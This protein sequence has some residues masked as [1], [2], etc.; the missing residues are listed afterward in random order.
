MDWQAF[1]WHKHQVEG[2]PNYSINKYG[3]LTF[4]LK[5]NYDVNLFEASFALFS[6]ELRRYFQE[7]NSTYGGERRAK[8][9]LWN[10]KDT[11]IDQ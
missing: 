1:S 3:G 6:P 4:L 10:N 5:C 2:F 9:I 8:F 7:L 11:T